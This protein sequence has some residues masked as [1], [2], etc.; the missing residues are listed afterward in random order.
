MNAP[1]ETPRL[2]AA[3]KRDAATALAWTPEP[4]ALRMWAGPSTRLPATVDSLWEDITSTDAHTY[5]FESATHGLVGFGQVRLKENN[6]GH[7]AR[8]IVS[9][10]HRGQGLGRAWC[11]ALMRE[12]VRS[13]GV[14]AFSLYVY[15]DNT[16]AISLYRS[17]G[18]VEC[19]MHEKFNCILMRAPLS[20]LALG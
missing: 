12:A 10:R 18:F 5:A 6:Y 1:T 3:S 8:L 15:P 13:H 2:R 19:G 20:A 16:R 4:D 11:A 17:L 7:L 9:P 14:A